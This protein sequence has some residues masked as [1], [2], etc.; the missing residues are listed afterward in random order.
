MQKDF[1]RWNTLKKQTNSKSENKFYKPRDVWW[2]RLGVN[3]GSEQDGKERE[4]T[5][6]ILIVAPMSDKTCLVVPLTISTE[7][8][9]HRVSIG[10]IDNKQ[11]K[12]I[13]SQ[14]KVVDIKRLVLKIYRLDV[15]NFDKVKKSI[16]S[17]F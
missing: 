8:H 7:T 14:M 3:I 12:A 10:L 17:F 1:D 5:R 11:A 13:V 9:R 16:R 15:N 2:C 4:F 6:P